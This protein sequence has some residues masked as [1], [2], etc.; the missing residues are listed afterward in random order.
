MI[1]INSDG[2]IFPGVVCLIAV[3]PHLLQAMQ[4]AQYSIQYLN[5]CQEVMKSRQ[6][7]IKS[8]LSVFQEEEDLL[9][10]EI[11]KYK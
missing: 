7:T 9:D 3:D 11:A 1:Y 5:S 6:D 10:F 2:L 8:A 4:I